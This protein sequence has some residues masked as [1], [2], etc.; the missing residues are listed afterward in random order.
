MKSGFQNILRK[1]AQ[2]AYSNVA[3]AGRN[4]T[5]GD[6]TPMK[7]LVMI[8]AALA[9]ATTTAFAA[10]EVM[11]SVPSHS[12]TVTDWY[13]QS[14]Y[15]TQ[16]NKIGDIK[17]VLVD[18]DGRI[19]ALIISVGGF[20]G[21]GEKDVAV[22]FDAV[23]KTE[24]NNSVQLTMNASKDELKSAPGLKYDKQSTSWVPDRSNNK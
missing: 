17:D 6:E 19:N 1:M 13:K 7:R 5:H 11:T 22:K 15:D 4:R 3:M 10:G 20:L 8:G 21:A 23:K 9:V 12:V 18:S 16:N 2:S 14:V 24:K